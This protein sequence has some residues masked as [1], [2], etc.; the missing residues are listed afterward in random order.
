MTNIF[1]VKPF[2][3]LLI[4]LYSLIP[5]HDFGVAVI[6]MTSLI[7][8]L[9]WPLAAKALHGQK[10]MQKIQP[11]IERLKKKY[12]EPQELNKAMMELYKEKEVS[13]FGSCLPS[14]LQIPFMLGL[15]YTFNKF[16]NPNFLEVKNMVEGVQTYI[17]PFVKD[18]SFVKNTF[19]ASSVIN[20]NFLGLMNL[21]K[22]SIYLGIVAGAVQFVQ[23]KMMMPSKVQDQ[24]QKAMSRTVLLFP[25]ITVVFGAVLPAA[26]PLYWATT[27]LVAI[28]QQYLIIHRDVE[29]MEHLKGNSTK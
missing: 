2:L 5:G 4:V 12:K 10:E 11:D 21:A 17:Y 6:L 7:R 13:P 22:P 25:A 9:M 19:A 16:K 24:A 15:F 26:L 8:F 29:Y 23:A 27:T 20:T 1:I 18:F 3:N 14:L 28:L